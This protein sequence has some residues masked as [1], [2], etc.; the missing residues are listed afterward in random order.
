MT[1]YYISVGY[2]ARAGASVKAGLWQELKEAALDLC[3]HYERIALE[4]HRL[5][6]GYS[7]AALAE[8]A[9]LY[10]SRA[11]ATIQFLEPPDEEPQIMQLASGGGLGRDMKEALRR[12]FARLLIQEM[13]KKR[14]EVNLVVV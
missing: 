11:D 9:E 2:N 8:Y 1:G 7:V 14:I 10:H 3:E 5:E 4:A 6:S 13:H 12:A